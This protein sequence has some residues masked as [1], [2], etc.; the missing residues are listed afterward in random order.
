MDAL[1]D[2]YSRYVECGELIFELDFT[3][4]QSIFESDIL[5]T[6]WSAISYEF[7]YC[8]SKP[9]IY[10]NTPMKIM[11]PYWER[12]GLEPMDITL[13]DKIGTSIDVGDIPDSLSD[14]VARLLADE[15]AFREQI[16]KILR[17]YVFYPGRS[18]E[19]GGRYIIN[20]LMSAGANAIRPQI[21]N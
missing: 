5:I 14:A 21:N 20:E 3:S 15:D 16:Y 1:A 9:C 12:Y 6:D 18:G 2:S 10:I 4:S 8:T 7:G 17:E 19:A 11:N 13:R